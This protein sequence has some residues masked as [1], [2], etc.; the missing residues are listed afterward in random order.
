MNELGVIRKRKNISNNNNSVEDTTMDLK[1]KIS[2]AFGILLITGIIFG[3]LSS[4]P[5]LENQN[6]LNKLSLI[7]LQVLIATFFQFAMA[8]VYVFIAVLLYP[9]IKQYDERIALGYF[10]FRIIGAMFL[11]IGIVSLLLLLFISQ[12]FVSSGQP[13]SSHFQTIGQLLRVGRDWMNHVAMILPW[14]IGGLLLYYSFLRMKIIPIWLS[15]W[16]LI[17]STLTLIATFMLMFDLIKIVTPIYFILL[18]PTAIFELVLAVY[19][20]I[21]GFSTPIVSSSIPKT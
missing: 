20:I 1:R 10:G 5:A 3:I 12:G 4:V 14:S 17:G 6:Y 21:K 13:D 7:K 18:I 11:F 15:L 16:G 8:S 2:I 19:M 9:V